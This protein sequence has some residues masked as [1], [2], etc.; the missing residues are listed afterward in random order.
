[1]K[2]KKQTASK[3]SASSPPETIN[4]SPKTGVAGRERGR[5]LKHEPTRRPASPKAQVK[6]QDAAMN[7]L[8]ARVYTAC[9]YLE[10]FRDSLCEAL[11][12]ASPLEQPRLVRIIREADKRGRSFMA[13][14]PSALA[15]LLPTP[16]D[17][18]GVAHA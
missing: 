7:E 18:A 4:A 12:T 6:S 9:A 11:R 14:P 17:F 8:Q 15:A 1:M 5:R 2:P 3:P 13:C 10:G 16:P